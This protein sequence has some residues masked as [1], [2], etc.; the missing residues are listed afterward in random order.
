MLYVDISQVFNL[1]FFSFNLV[2]QLKVSGGSGPFAHVLRGWVESF[3]LICNDGYVQYFVHLSLL[4]ITKANKP[5]N[6]INMHFYLLW[7]LF[8]GSSE[9]YRP[10]LLGSQHVKL[11]TKSNTTVILIQTF[12]FLCAALSVT[13][14]TTVHV[15][16]RLKTLKDLESRLKANEMWRQR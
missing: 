2:S 4:I 13:V 14:R 9:V 7:S 11:C 5:A 1:F 3:M 15:L 12:A 10:F 16:N 8:I 6:V